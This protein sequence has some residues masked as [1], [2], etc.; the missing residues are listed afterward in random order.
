LCLA[1]FREQIHLRGAKFNLIY[2]NVLYNQLNHTYSN[3]IDNSPAPKQNAVKKRTAAE[4]LKKKVI[5]V[6]RT[7]H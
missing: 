5:A 7:N 6:Y 1:K 3:A 4:K 2:K